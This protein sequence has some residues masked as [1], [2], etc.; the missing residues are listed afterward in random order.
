MRV[1]HWVRRRVK[2]VFAGF[3]VALAVW[4]PGVWAT[5]FDFSPP[6]RNP[7]A[8]YSAGWVTYGIFDP[9]QNRTISE[10]VPSAAP[11]LISTNQGVV[12][13]NGSGVVY[14]RVYDPARTNWVGLAEGTGGGLDF[15]NDHGVVAWSSPGAVHA[16]VYE[17]SAG[18]WR[19]LDE[20]SATTYNLRV[21]DGIVAWSTASE[22]HFAC[23]DP[24]R[25]QWKAQAVA[26]ANVLDLVNTNGV[27]AWSSS[28]TV[29]HAVYDPIPGRWQLAQAVVGGPV[30]LRSADGVLAW[31]TGPAV[32]CRVYDGREGA[33]QSETAVLG[34]P[35]NLAIT[36]G[37]V[38]WSM[39]GGT[40]TRAYDPDA[41]HWTN[42]PTPPL[43]LFAVSADRG[44]APH[45]VRFMDMSVG[46]VAWLW[47]F[48]DGRQSSERAPTHLFE[49]LG[50]YTV[51][52]QVWNPHGQS[53]FAT[54]ILTDVE[55]PVGSLQINGGADFT[56]NA[57]V[58]LRLEATDN[59]GLAVEARLRNAGG[60]WSEWMPVPAEPTWLLPEGVGSRTVEAVFRDV[61]GNESEP[62]TAS[63]ELDT[64]PPPVLRFGWADTNLVESARTLTIPVELDHP[65]TR[66]VTARCL[67]EGGT[68]EPGRHFQPVDLE[69]V[70]PK[71]FTRGEVSLVLF[72]D[73][74]AEPDRT[75]VLRWV[76]P[77]NAL[78]GPPLTITV[79]DDDPARVRFAQE[80]FEVSEGD[81]IARAVV[82]LDGPAGLPVEVMAYA[83]NGTAAAGVDYIPATARLRFASGQTEAALEVPIVDNDL[84]QGTRTVELRLEALTNAVLTLPTTAQLL[85]LDNDPP[86]VNFAAREMVFRGGAGA[87][88]I[89]LV[90]SK[91]PAQTVLVDYATE[92]GGSAEP[93]R[94]Y[95]A[96]HDTLVW[97]AGESRRSLVVTVLANPQRREPR[98]LW[99]RLRDALNAYVGP[100]NLAVLRIEDAPPPRLR[101][102]RSTTGEW[103]VEADTVAG[104]VLQ[105]QGS[106]NLRQWEIRQEAT[107]LEGPVVFLEPGLGTKTSYYRVRVVR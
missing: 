63:I 93:G 60:E 7:T 53:V 65:F 56:T 69:V 64:T 1:E 99:L 83:T 37:V 67:S 97:P 5:V 20:A 66:R 80:A 29:F 55:P 46:A 24:A 73:E 14:C 76:D 95:V 17:P 36:N 26:A 101:L 34:Y 86:T 23:Y 70:F 47:D 59:S 77:I 50:R 13:W 35:S 100:D 44:P 85:I 45:R 54:N 28:G 42:R 41:R 6:L 4:A 52:L 68:A 58:A 30:A 21:A 12:V 16:R 48:G 75:V 19:S 3:G 71:G 90:L 106:S 92:Q 8:S 88:E 51:R 62:V 10:T 38:T 32:Y 11:G 79:E 96:V 25:G 31:A 40:A 78:V 49:G 104:A 22:V 15:R 102:T 105:L 57:L 61:Y 18:Q 87:V 27:V 89:Q 33:W 94:D 81:G 72:E 39:V 9:A 43:A 74:L 98:T 2:T 84:D 82:A 107:A 91:P 103:R